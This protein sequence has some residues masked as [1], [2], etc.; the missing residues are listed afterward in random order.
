MTSR[1]EARAGPIDEH[2]GRFAFSSGFLAAKTSG[3]GDLWILGFSGWRWLLRWAP[4][5]VGLIAGLLPLISADL[6]VSLG[7]AGLLVLGYSLAYAIGPPLLAVLLGGVGRRRILAAPSSGS[8]SGACTIALMP[9]FEGLV[10]VRTLWP[11]RRGR[12]PARRWRR[13]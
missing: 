5:R 11:W 7:Q 1:L 3:E 6:G 8:R 4:S 2:N 9:W 13:R 10:V 12:L